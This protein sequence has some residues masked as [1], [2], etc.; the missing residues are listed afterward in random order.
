M[1]HDTKHAD[2][3]RPEAFAGSAPGGAFDSA[4]GAFWRGQYEREAY[5]Q[6]G[7][8]WDD[9]EPAYRYGYDWH[10]RYPDRKF[11]DFERDMGSDWDKFKA[12]SRLKWEHAKHAVRAAW[13][14]A[15]HGKKDA[16]QH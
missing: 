6:S 14:R 12:K 3:T 2:K 8:T 15:V 5:F 11:E 10:H 7:M 9:Y 1:A 13:D 4:E 16:K